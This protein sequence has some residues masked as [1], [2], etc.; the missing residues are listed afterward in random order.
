[1]NKPVLVLVS[2]LA[3]FLISCGEVAVS[4]AVPTTA[5]GMVS[6]L[7]SE[8]SKL[9]LKNPE[10][11]LDRN[12]ANG[13]RRLIG[14]YGYSL[15]CPG[16]E[17]MPH[18]RIEQYGIKPINGTSDCIMSAEHQRL[19]QSATDYATRYNQALIERLDLK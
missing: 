9:D 16:A 14:I 6:L 12:L 19:I 7:R 18:D 5:S 1:M 11:D 17:K 13:D 4:N 3:A 8:L 2:F 15:H 10:K